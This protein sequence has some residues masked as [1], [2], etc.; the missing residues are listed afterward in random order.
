MATYKALQVGMRA[1]LSQMRCIR[2][3]RRNNCNSA[4]LQ[5]PL[6]ASLFSTELYRDVGIVVLCGLTASMLLTLSFLLV[7]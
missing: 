1:M 3:N 7:Y 2:N 4:H 6:L 5:K